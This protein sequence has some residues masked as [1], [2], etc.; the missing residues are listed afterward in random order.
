MMDD[1]RITFYLKPRQQ[2]SASVTEW[3]AWRRAFILATQARVIEQMSSAVLYVCPE[4]SILRL[5]VDDTDDE[6]I[7]RMVYSDI[8][9]DASHDAYMFYYDYDWSQIGAAPDFGAGS[10][11]GT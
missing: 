8:L 3:M 1:A 11:T 4:V 9:V 7:V 2:V 10:F 6:T 5:D